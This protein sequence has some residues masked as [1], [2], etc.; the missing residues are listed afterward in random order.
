MLKRLEI[1]YIDLLLL[2]FYFLDY[3]NAYKDIEKALSNG[4]VK[5]IRI[6]HFQNNKLEDLLSKITIKPVLNQIETHQL[7]ERCFKNNIKIEAWAPVGHVI[8][9]L[10]KQ[11]ILNDLSK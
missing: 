7:R 4:K 1:D 9:E 11:N 5:N 10:D 6:S 8:L 3:L 2:H